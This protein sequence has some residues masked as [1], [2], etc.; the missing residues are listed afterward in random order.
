MSRFQGI[1]TE[2]EREAL[3]PNRLEE[4]KKR[5]LIR[6]ESLLRYLREKISVIKVTRQ[7]RTSRRKIITRDAWK[8]KSGTQS[9]MGFCTKESHDLILE[10]A[11]DINQV[12]VIVKRARIY[13][14]WPGTRIAVSSFTKLGWIT[15]NVPK[16]QKGEGSYE[17]RISGIESAL[18][19]ELF[20][21]LGIVRL[22]EED[23]I[24]AT[25]IGLVEEGAVMKHEIIK[26]GQ[27]KLS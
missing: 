19:D 12:I 15:F 16:N 7:Y 8:S 21:V 1:N 2:K 24:N 10:L 5:L 27:Y 18:I 20:N 17:L 14:S 3:K 26:R 11:E 25:A 4:K 9:P 13:I 6:K 22:V 23:L